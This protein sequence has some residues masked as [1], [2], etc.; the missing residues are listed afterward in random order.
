MSSKRTTKEFIDLC[1][2]VHHS[3]YDYSK[4]NYIK[5]H[6]KICIICPKH[7]EFLQDANSHL[8]GCGCPK[9]AHEHLSIINA[10][11][12]DEFIKDATNI[13]GDY[14]DY[15]NVH[16]V[17]SCT[18][19]KIVC[20]IHGEFLQT[21]SDHLSGCKCPKCSNTYS[22]QDWFIEKCNIIHNNFYN[23]SRT[24]YINNRTEIIIICPKHG[25]FMQLPSNHIKGEGCPKCKQEKLSKP[26]FSNTEIINRFIKVHGN[27]YDYTKV[28]YKGVDT[29]VTIKCLKHGEFLQTPYKHLIG[30]G[31]PKCK[32]KGQSILFELLRE[33]FPEAQWEWEWTADWL[34]R[35]RIDI[36][37]VNYKIAIEYDGLQHQIP[38]KHFGG[39]LGFNNRLKLD[40][41]KELK[42]RK[43]NVHLIRINYNY[44]NNDLVNLFCKIETLLKNTDDRSGLIKS[45]K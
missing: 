29:L 6:T 44:N 23:Y 16:Y 30:Q 27:R 24:N 32:L 20:P 21:P 17:N 11:T 7:G 9:C 34:G 19:V 36:Y 12:L 45:I 33:K 43:Q 22:G 13:H 35:Q 8:R 2:K 25:E 15:S 5:A 14:Y 38:I 18:K 31:C 26:K 41:L 1:N 4:I 42:C 39:I 37:S 10:K 28:D 3:F 40:Q